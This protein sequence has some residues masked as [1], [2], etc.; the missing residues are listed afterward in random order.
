M[1]DDDIWHEIKSTP[2]KAEILI[3]VPHKDDYRYYVAR[4]TDRERTEMFTTRDGRII[5]GATEWQ[6]IGFL[7]GAVHPHDIID[8]RD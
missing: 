4:R 2:K 5:E 3:R 6:H 8:V 7:P 1:E